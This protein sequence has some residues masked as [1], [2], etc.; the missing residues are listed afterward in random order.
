MCQVTY[1]AIDDVVYEKF[2]QRKSVQAVI[3]ENN[4]YCRLG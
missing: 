4:I 2:F 3:Q 1:L